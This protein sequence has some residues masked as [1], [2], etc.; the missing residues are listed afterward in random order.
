MLENLF[1]YILKL[2]GK[3]KITVSDTEQQSNQEYNKEY[4]DIS[5]IN[6]TAI[7]SNRLAHYVTSDSEVHVLGKNARAM[8][9]EDTAKAITAKL[10]KTIASALGTGGCAL[11]PYVKGG[12][13]YFDTVKQ[14]RI[15]INTTEGDRIT[16]ATVLADSIVVDNK[17]Y[18]RFVDYSVENGILH[19]QNKVTNSSGSP[20]VVEQWANIADMYISDVDRVLFG[21]IKCPVDNRRNSDKYGV[22]ITYGCKKLID[23][24]KSCLEQIEEEFALKKVRLQVDT[25]TLDKDP[26]TG[27]PILKDDLFIK[28]TSTDG[29]LFNIFNPDIRE[30]SFHARLEKLC[31]LVE[32][33]VGT[34]KGILTPRETSGATAT[35]IRASMQD[36]F[37]MIS[38]I[39]AMTEKGLVDFFYACN[40]LANYYNLSPSSDYEVKFDWSYAL[41]ESSTET[42]QQKQYL[43]SQGG[44]STGE[45][46]AWHTG[47]DMDTAKKAVETIK[48]E[49]PRLKDVMAL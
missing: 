43:H 29:D 23:D 48:K 17:V 16:Q 10:T 9:L 30:S 39:R 44:L 49:E 19:I 34:S 47:E 21:Y 11:V 32:K 28:G 40:V 5:D 35:E 26:K 1:K 46:R 20:A 36:T 45:L 18:Y 4:M 22:P 33:A 37:D 2:L 27:K 7:F 12:K 15:L 24:I 42:W 13:L 41:L 31:A 6:I 25:R 14:N 8:L 38:D 3:N